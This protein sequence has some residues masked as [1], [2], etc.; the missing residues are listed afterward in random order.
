MHILTPVLSPGDA[1]THDA[2]GMVRQLRCWGWQA[3]AYAQYCDGRLRDLAQPLAAFE[4]FLKARRDWLIYHH[5]VGWPLG[6]HL[7]EHSRNRRILRY[8]SVTPAR[9]FRRYQPRYAAGCQ[10]GEWQTRRLLRD[11]PIRLLAD[12]HHNFAELL[13]AGARPEDCRVVPPFHAAEEL[14]NLPADPRLERMLQG[15]PHVVFVGKVAPNKGH[16]HLLRVFALFHRQAATSQLHIVGR[17]DPQLGDYV[18]ELRRQVSNLGLENAVRFHGSVSPRQLRTFYAKAHA[19]LCTSEH[20]GFGVP[21]VEAM[22]FGVPVVAQAA[23]AVRETLGPTGLVWDS[24]EPAL[25]AEGLRAVCTAGAIRQ[26]LIDWQRW[27]YECEFRPDRIAERFM[28]VWDELQLT[29]VR[30]VARHPGRSMAA[31]AI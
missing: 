28:A 17:L 14:A 29:P 18:A 22:R 7:W 25:L 11:R 21:L 4:P 26:L 19:F 1:V 24:A 31:S 15:G 3:M 27:R 30:A 23:G 12:S 20:E 9:F 5:S 8:H 6:Q 13:A 16:R 2:L 10:F